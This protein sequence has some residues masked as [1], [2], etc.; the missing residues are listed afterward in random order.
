MHV[1]GIFW[2]I[3]SFKASR[4]LQT[5]RDFR[6]LAPFELA[7][8]DDEDEETLMAESFFKPLNVGNLTSFCSLEENV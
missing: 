3:P 6:R 8:D 1:Y 2:L 7:N 5:T 4:A